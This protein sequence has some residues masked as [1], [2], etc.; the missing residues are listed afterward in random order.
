M[1]S[2]IL[3][4][5]IDRAIVPAILLLATRI[6]SIT[7]ICRYLDLPVKISKSGFVFESFADFVK[8]NSYSTLVMTTVLIAGISY[9][10]IKSLAFHNSHVKPALSAKIF[11]FKAHHLIQGSFH[12]YS[13]AVIWLSYAYLLLLFTGVMVTS[14]LL[15]NWVFYIT[16]GVTLVS[17]VLFM[18]DVEEE[19]KIKGFDKSRGEYEYDNDKELLLKEELE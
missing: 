12:L 8:V 5:L 13:E 14:K 11:S 19:L 4:K 1:L 3:I 17:T 6:V 7:L 16:A 15:Y 9:I 18:F 2:K 10:L